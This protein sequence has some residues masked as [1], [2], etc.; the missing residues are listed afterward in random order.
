MHRTVTFSAPV[1]AGR[2][3]SVL[4]RG[5][6]D[7]T[8]RRV[9]SAMWRTS[10]METGPVTVSVVQIDRQHRRGRGLGPWC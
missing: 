10:R 1:D 5:G 4:R 3:W 2:T 6:G 7:P 8:F 9:G